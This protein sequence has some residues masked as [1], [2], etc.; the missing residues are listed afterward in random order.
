VGY[1]YSW[2]EL[3]SSKRWS[4]AEWKKIIYGGDEMAR[5]QQ[6]VAPPSWYSQFRKNANGAP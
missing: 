4:D 1:V 5:K 6:G 3:S 2:F